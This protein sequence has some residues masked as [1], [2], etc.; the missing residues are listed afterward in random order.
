[1]A[2]IPIDPFQPTPQAGL[3]DRFQILALDG[4]GLKGIFSAAILAALE[5]DHGRKIIDCFDL[6][7]GTSTGGLI[8]L[9]LGLGI[10]PAELVGF[11]TGLGPGVF[12]GRRRLRSVRHLFRPKYGA[13]RLHH[14]LVE[15]FGE[16][17]LA[18][19][20]KRLV[21]PAFNLGEASVHIFKTP[22]HPRLKRDWRVTM[23]DVAMATTAAPTFFRAHRLAQM[24]LIDG[25]VWANNP[26]IVGVAEAVS[27][28]GVSLDAIRVFSVGTTT[29]LKHHT[30]RLDTGGILP[31][32]TKGSILDVVLGGQSIGSDNLAHH[33]LGKDRVLRLNPYVPAHLF[34]LDRADPKE[35]IGKAAA[36]SR[37]VGPMFQLI[38]GD[39]EAP[40]YTPLYKKGLKISHV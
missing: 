39:H 4:G 30:R 31:W 9:G 38:C 40:A 28:L 6:I 25:G 5:V 34:A 7:T 23:V 8:A 20:A 33:L 35:L 12:G 11:Y 29:D 15:I 26:T 24:R 1:M 2:R 14:A 21:I 13:K 19:S 27:M 10:S 17:T 18:D 3:A 22:H 36:H 37:S 16:H 32:A